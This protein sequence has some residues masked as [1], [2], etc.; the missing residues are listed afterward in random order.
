MKK[1]DY[2]FKKEDILDLKVG[3]M[4][5]ITGKAF[6]RGETPFI[7]EFMTAKNRQWI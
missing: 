7:K 1:L 6:H 2:P 4:V 3:D 5:L